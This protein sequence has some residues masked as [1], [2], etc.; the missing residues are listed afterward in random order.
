[1]ESTSSARI[2]S[3]Q[4]IKRFRDK[5]YRKHDDHRSR[6]KPPS[7]IIAAIALGAGPTNDNLIDEVIAIA[8]YMRKLIQHAE[9]S[10]QLLEVR[11]PSHYP[12]IFTDRW[13]KIRSDQQLW[14]SDLMILIERLEMLKR[15]GFDPAV[16]QITFDD[17]FGE[18]AGEVALRDY[19]QAQAIQLEH[20]ALGMTPSGKLQTQNP[21][22]NLS[23]PA[24]GAGVSASG[25]ITPA[26][27]NTNMGGIIP[28]ENCW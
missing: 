7:V 12:D 16:I 14:A 21:A 17:L 13:P 4:L 24:L 19:H 27:A 9:A 23:A 26:R 11:N 8:R 5:R 18:K 28:D 2:V 20:G 1:M 6:R 25:L 3:L 15:V 22:Q 10:V